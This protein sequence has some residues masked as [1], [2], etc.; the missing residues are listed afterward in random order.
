MQN[1]LFTLFLAAFTLT[2]LHVSAI[3]KDDV[4]RVKQL[5]AYF[6][7]VITEWKVPG[8]AV[9]IVKDDSVILAN[10]YGY[11]NI[12]TK[13]PVDENTVFPIASITKSFTSAAIATLVDEGKLNWNDK[14][15]DYLP[16]FELYSPY[17]SENMT[18][19]DLLC[20]RS[21]LKTFSGDL[22]WYGTDYTREE[23]IRRAKYLE[24]AYGFRAHYGYSNIMFMAAGEVIEAVTGKSYEDYIAEEFLE[25]LS[26]NRTVP[27][28]S[29]MKKMDN[30]ATA[31]TDKEGEVITIPF[32]NWDNVGAA[33]LLNSSVQDMTQWIKLQLNRG[34]LSGKEY[35]SKE[36]NHEMWRAHMVQEVNAGSKNLWPTTHFKAYGLGWGMNDYYGKK[37]VGHGGGY[38]G[39]ISYLGMVPGEKLGF[40]ILTNANSLL[41]YAMRYTILDA[42][43]SEKDG[44]DWSKVMLDYQKKRAENQQKQE[45]KL[46]EERMKNTSP[47][48][49]LKE[50][51]GTYGGKMYGNAEVTVD[52]G[53]LTVQLLPAEKFKGT[54]THWHYNTF[55]IEFRE[56]PSL[57]KGSCHFILDKNGAV[58]EMKIDVPN[59]DFDFTELKFLKLEQD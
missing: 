20:H 59:P 17:V 11:K 31:H 43:L 7:Q 2:T 6:E 4:K 37:V 18:I 52:N 41:Y 47:T 26:M 30:T 9:A 35:F 8:M 51:A 38:D 25:P 29:Q 34:T 28:I 27:S 3:D 13:E 39:I 23:I 5:K 12:E 10:G 24:P 45:E 42:F 54:L 53:Q 15:R 16:W 22:L 21:G 55:R 32:L 36:A 56:F 1:K 44:K 14:V 46:A 19:T 58:K 49:H 40:I 57:P 33:G 48:L 50:F